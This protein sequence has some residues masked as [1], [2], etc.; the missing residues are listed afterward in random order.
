[1]KYLNEM[2]ILPIL[3]LILVIGSITLAYM[4]IDGWGWFLVVFV[5]TCFGDDSNN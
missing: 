2:S 5:L 1:M 3:Q 4:G